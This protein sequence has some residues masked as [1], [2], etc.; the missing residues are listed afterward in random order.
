MS[1]ITGPRHSREEI[2]QRGDEIYERVVLPNVGPDD[3]GKF[4][5]IDIET[6]DYE[7]DRDEVAA[8]DRLVERHPEAKGWLRQ[9]GS[10]YAY[11]FGTHRSATRA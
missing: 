10:R 3:E 7:I 9:I 5:V 6:G 8:T 2:A 1:Q 4:V 11:R